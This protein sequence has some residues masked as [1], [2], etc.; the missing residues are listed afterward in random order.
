MNALTRED[1]AGYSGRFVRDYATSPTGEV[2][3]LQGATAAW[4]QEKKVALSGA[5]RL[6]DRTVQVD[7]G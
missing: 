2:A 5:R 1:E 7:V 3:Q 6:T 4:L